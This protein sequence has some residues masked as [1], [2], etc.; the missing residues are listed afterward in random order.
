MLL[1]ITIMKATSDSQRINA[2]SCIHVSYI[3]RKWEFR[4]GRGK[5]GKERQR[6]SERF[7]FLTN[8]RTPKEM[9]ILRCDSTRTSENVCEIQDGPESG[10]EHVIRMDDDWLAKIAKDG[11]P[12]IP[13]RLPK[14]ESG[15]DITGGH[16]G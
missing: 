7:I 11:K 14:R 4:G 13:G 5:G 16:V 1:A 2:T 8:K 3:P 15:I 12:N 6:I 10:D 9:R